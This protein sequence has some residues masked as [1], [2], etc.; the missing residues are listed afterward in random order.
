MLASAEGRPSRR[1]ARQRAPSGQIAAEAT[2]GRR[3]DD[4]DRHDRGRRSPGRDRQVGLLTTKQNLAVVL[5]ILPP[6]PRDR[7]GGLRYRAAENLTPPHGLAPMTVWTALRTGAG[8]SR[9]MSIT[10]GRLSLGAT[11]LKAA[12]SASTEASLD[13]P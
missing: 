7:L 13:A 4:G 9:R 3:R 11:A 12:N 8:G 2:H 1:A 10:G 6:P 5:P